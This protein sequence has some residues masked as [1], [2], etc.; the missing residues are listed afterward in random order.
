M[1]DR[2]KPGEA[3]WATVILIGVLLGYPLSFGPAE[4]VAWRFGDPEWLTGIKDRVYLPL[5]QVWSWDES[6]YSHPD[7]YGS[8]LQWWVSRGYDAWLRAQEGA[9]TP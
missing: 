8:Y 1:T 2:K 9:V 6:G 3:F 7:W 4:Y 5:F